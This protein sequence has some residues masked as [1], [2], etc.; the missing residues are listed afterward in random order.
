MPTEHQQRANP[1]QSMQGQELKFQNT[2][3]SAL[4]L[5]EDAGQAGHRGMCLLSLFQPR[6]LNVLPESPKAEE[7]YFS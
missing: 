2:S 7:V 6:N 3:K 1:G 5:G 4:G